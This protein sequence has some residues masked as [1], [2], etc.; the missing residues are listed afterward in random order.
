MATGDN[1]TMR[2]MKLS[3]FLVMTPLLA[4]IVLLGLFPG[5]MIETME[6][7][8]KALVAHVQ[9]HSDDDRANQAEVEKAEVGARAGHSGDEGSDVEGSETEE[10]H[11]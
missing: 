3:E 8:V 9:V 11:D 7:S 10:G 5:P 4:L 2:D 1:A 6:P